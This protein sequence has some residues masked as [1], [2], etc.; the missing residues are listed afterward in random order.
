MDRQTDGWTDADGWTD[1]WM[2]G[3]TLVQRCVGATKKRVKPAKR[4][5]MISA[6]CKETSQHAWYEKKSKQCEQKTKQCVQKSI[7]T[8]KKAS[9][10]IE[11]E[12]KE[13]VQAKCKG[14]KK[15][16]NHRW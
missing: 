14:S 9:N 8:S 10:V 6:F 1:G 15:K 3:K 11:K 7:D 16:N 13:V 2:D 4:Q 5:K 12:K